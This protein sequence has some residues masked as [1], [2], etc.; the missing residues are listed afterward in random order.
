MMEQCYGF[1]MYE[2]SLI[3][4]VFERFPSTP[5]KSVYSVLA[6]LI[7]PGGI[8]PFSK[9]A[10]RVSAQHSSF[11]EAK[12]ALEIM[13]GLSQTQVDMLY[14]ALEKQYNNET[15][16]RD[17]AH[18]MAIYSLYT[19]NRGIRLDNIASFVAGSIII[20]LGGEVGDYIGDFTIAGSY[21]GDVDSA[22]MGL[23]DMNSDLDT[24]NLWNVLEGEGDGEKILKVITDYNLAVEN[25]DIN[26][27]NE[28]LLSKG[29]GSLE[30]GYECLKK[31]LD[32]TNVLS[33]INSS[34]KTLTDIEKTKE[35]F[36][37]HIRE[38]SD[39]KA[40]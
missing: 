1:S 29:D 8:K 5:Y 22:S 18:E 4:T 31:E 13:C 6:T 9:L 19:H 38:T 35:K 32:E 2:A 30:K 26:R 20:A 10:W 3:R 25:G 34:G 16:T 23:D 37:R 15:A 28:F 39:V 7:Y 14:K 12:K 33:T 11:D 27:T 17:F 36:L 24:Y 21:K 40:E